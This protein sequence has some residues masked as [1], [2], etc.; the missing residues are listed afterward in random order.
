MTRRLPAF[1]PRA[2]AACL[3]VLA[4]A[5]AG[6]AP[7][8][9]L[10]TETGFQHLTQDQ[11]L[12]N[13]VTTAVT[14]D[15]DGFLWVGTHG[16]LARWD[17][18]RFVVHRAD[19]QAPGALPDNL[20]QA[21]HTDP[22]G[23]LWIGT[24]SAGLT[25]LDRL[26]GRFTTIPAG[27]AGLSHVSVHAIADDGVGGLWVGTGA[28][29]DRV[30]LAT[31]VVQ[32]GIG[33]LRGPRVNALLTDRRG[34][35][36]AATSQGLMRRPANEPEFKPLAFPAGVAGDP[37]PLA[38]L[39]DGTGRLWVGTVRHGAWWL[40]AGSE[41]LQPLAETDPQPDFV[42]ALQQVG[43]AV[44]ARPGE[45]WLGTQAGGVVAVDTASLQT[46]R[47][48]HRPTLPMSLADNTVRGLH[49]DR[50]GLLWVAT[51]RGLS[52][53]DPRQTA[54]LTMYGPLRAEPAVRGGEVPLPAGSEVSA[55]LPLPDG[56]LWLGTQRHGIEIVDPIGARVGA[57]RPDATRPDSA[58][59]PEGVTGLVRIADGR[60]LAATKRGLYG[61]SADGTRVQRLPLGR[62]DEAAALNTL[63]DA[64]DGSVW[65]GG[66]SDGLWQLQLDSGRAERHPRTAATPLS[67]E[68]VT[69]I[70]HADAGR[71]WVGT[72]YGLNRFDPGNGQVQ[73]IVPEPGRADG[74]AAGFVTALLADRGNRLWVGTYGGGIHLLEGWGIDGKPRFRRVS[75][76][77]GLPDDNVNALVEDRT[78]RVW[79]ST[80]NGF[81][82]IDPTTLAVRVLKRAEGVAFATYWTGAAARTDEGELLFGGA[83]GMSIVQPE[84]LQPWTYQPRVVLTDVR[85]G[86][87]TVATG[88]LQGP[89]AVPLK[90]PAGTASLAVEFAAMDFSAPSR[91]RYAY[92]LQG[93]DAD[94]IEVDA[95]RRVASYTNLPP[96]DYTLQLRGSNRDGIWSPNEVALAVQVL[97]AWHQSWW[98]RGAVLLLA[99]GTLTAFVQVRTGRLRRT[100]ADLE[101]KVRA[102]TAELEAVSAALREKS[103]VLELTSVSDPLTGLRNRRFLTQNLE[104]QLAASLRRAVDGAPTADTDTVFLMIDIDHFKRVNDEHGHAAGD[105]VLLQVAQR[106]Q[107]T[108]RESDHVVRW[109]GEEFL[110]VARDTD[111]A[112]AEELA[113]RIRQAVRDEPFDLE[114][115]RELSLTCSIGFACVP[116]LPHEPRAVSWPDVVQLA[117]I[118][119]LAAKRSGRDG[120]VGLSAGPAAHADGLRQCVEAD[121]AAMVQ[122]Q[123]LLVRASRPLADV[124]DAMDPQP[125][126]RLTV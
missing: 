85:V 67:D 22:A 108:M 59:P 64:G 107:Q 48:R 109:G 5:L 8:W 56:R 80:D 60:V 61:V 57:I 95:T 25:S 26:S 117:D 75:A 58:L 19:P 69:V 16:G 9:S 118:A 50:A 24:S 12:P 3:L 99:L 94:W 97:P 73:A 47:I 44:E 46:R 4:A 90:V 6:A 39:Q 27:R 125:P 42:L 115:E 21:L 116:F 29:L 86:S 49:R 17:G 91:N 112:R 2:A 126:A 77:N 45:V 51:Q 87:R 82:S 93:F 38:L 15:A 54:V 40:D 88:P 124:I 62:R 120:W 105:A 34:T 33:R 37:E 32:R 13:E 1:L 72:R 68:R 102:R 10:L 123:A 84:R 121:A 18:Y 20:V 52:R 113:E 101:I 122:A 55:I 43:S 78:G 30:D 114:G 31:G 23:R 74:L 83:G 100:Q 106:L 92:R 81:A 89:G 41:I 11:G 65:L 70:A 66:Q 36:W 103:A 111:R 63:F 28:G 71:L 119:L 110:A 76:A 104:A 98:F 35:L 7:R 79:A 14:E 53:H 96:G